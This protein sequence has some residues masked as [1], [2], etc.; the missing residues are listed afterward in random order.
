M[1]PVSDL[2]LRKEQYL[3]NI[4]PK[5]QNQFQ[6]GKILSEGR[7]MVVKIQIRKSN[8]KILFAEAE[9]EFVDF[10][11]SFLTFPLGRVLHM[12]EGFSSVS[13]ID[14]LYR[15]MNELSSDRYLTSQ[16]IKEKLANPPCAPQFN[17]IYDAPKVFSSCNINDDF[18]KTVKKNLR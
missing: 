4:N 1:T 12:L 11:F 14:K 3:S 8:R 9:E 16:G 10:L 6:F 15:S 18:M 7:Q 5:N 17:L 13:C 2:I